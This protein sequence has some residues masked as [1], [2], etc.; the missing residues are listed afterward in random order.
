MPNTSARR[1]D[2]RVDDVPERY[3]GHARA[4]AIAVAPIPSRRRLTFRETT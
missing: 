2:V 1:A 3:I 4:A